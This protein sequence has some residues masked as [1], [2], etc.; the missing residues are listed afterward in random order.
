MRSTSAIELRNVRLLRGERWILRGID[1][2][3]PAGACA[4]ILGPNGSGKSTLARIIGG[5]LYPTQGHV[6]VLGHTF[7]EVDLSALRQRIRLV[8]P[9][10]PYDVDGELSV[11]QVI[12][13]GFFA[14]LG[15]YD[16]VS[17]AQQAESLRIVRQVG[18]AG[19][20]GNRYSTLSSGERV[21]ALIGR[22]LAPRPDLL[23]LDEPTSGLDLLAREQVLAT[24]QEVRAM[25]ADHAQQGA[26]GGALRP[27]AP[28]RPTVLMITHHVEELPPDVATIL[29]LDEGR[30]G[31]K[32]P[33]QEV[34]RADILSRV[35]RCPVEVSSHHGRYSLHVHPS[36]WKDLLAG[37][38]EGTGGRPN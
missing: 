12:Q 7:G 1:W 5:H 25:T 22:A 28:W 30:V 15:L 29:L 9:A 10:G 21:R 35:Y 33:P 31:A 24:I 16:Q 6:A 2:L 17:D 32:G 4:A 14:T 26:D 27:D 38:S 19:V 20:A 18:L 8:Q 37:S 23:L 13:S 34:L 11:M 3:V 36:A